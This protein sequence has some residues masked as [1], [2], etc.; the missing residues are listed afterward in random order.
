MQQVEGAM[1]EGLPSDGTLITCELDPT[2]AGIARSWFARSPHGAKIELRQGPALETVGSL[3]G[4]FD[5]AFV[6]AD[7]ENYP[8]YYQACLGKLRRS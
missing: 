8:H 5:L 1:A 2:H 7:K 6:D 4:S 3:A